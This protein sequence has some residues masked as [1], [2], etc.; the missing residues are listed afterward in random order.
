GVVVEEG[1]LRGRT[2]GMRWDLSF[3]DQ[4]RP[5][6]T[7]PAWAWERE[8]LPAAQVVPYPT[9]RV[10][11]TFAAG[12]EELTVEDGIG[13]LAR[14]YGHGNAERWG[15]VHA[16]LGG[17]DVLEVVA[18]APRRRGPLRLPLVPVMQLRLAGRD[19]P[20]RQLG[21]LRRTKV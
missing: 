4:S 13:N 11:G 14:I 15:W 10:V 20:A 17:G 19:W 6:L 21:L 1:A 12:D 9:A 7:F 2:D 8:L 3:V 16:D 5:L 18:A